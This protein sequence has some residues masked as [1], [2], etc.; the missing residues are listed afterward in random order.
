MKKPPLDEL[1]RISN[2]MKAA[3]A[4]GLAAMIIS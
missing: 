3:M 1:P 4:V 2:L